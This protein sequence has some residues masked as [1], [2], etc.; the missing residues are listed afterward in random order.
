MQSVRLAIN[1]RPCDVMVQPQESLLQLLRDK[2]G[3]KGTKEGCSTGYCGACT[4][5]VDGA[6]VNSCLFFAVDADRREVTTIEGLA[7]D[8][9]ALH[10]LQ[11]AFVNA[12]G[13]QC[14]FCTPGMIMSAAALLTEQPSPSE[15]EVRASLAG[16]ICRCTGYQ[17]IVNAVLAAAEEMRAQGRSGER[18]ASAARLRSRA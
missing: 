11:N 14:G 9:G 4:V 2:L 10:S 18:P 15:A 3:L 6:P 8:D 17:S 12:G 5:L 16:N 1:G 7:A 13:L